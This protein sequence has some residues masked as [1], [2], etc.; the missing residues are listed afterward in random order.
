MFVAIARYISVLVFSSVSR[1]RCDKLGPTWEQ[2]CDGFKFL[3]ADLTDVRNMSEKR[4]WTEAV[5]EFNLMPTPSLRAVPRFYSSL[6]FTS[7]E[8]ESGRLSLR[9]S[10]ASALPPSALSLLLQ[11][12]RGAHYHCL[13]TAAESEPGGSRQAAG[14]GPAIARLRRLAFFG[15]FTAGQRASLHLSSRRRC[16]SW[17]CSHRNHTAGTGGYSGAGRR[18][19]RRSPAAGGA[20][21]AL[22]L[23]G[24]LRSRQLKVIK[25]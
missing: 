11:Y 3:L 7:V 2:V 19:R 1:D 6:G 21:E 10:T 24:G 14:T 20:A 5:I 12:R 4:N 18:K 8:R 15:R 23:P 16:S 25:A 17:S 9:A 22:G 13:R